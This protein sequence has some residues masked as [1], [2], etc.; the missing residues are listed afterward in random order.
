[1][2]LSSIKLFYMIE[3]SEHPFFT[4]N[5]LTNVSIH[6]YLHLPL[7]LHHIKT[8]T[9]GA[10]T[11]AIHDTTNSLQHRSINNTLIP[12]LPTTAHKVTYQQ[13][14]FLQCSEL[15]CLICI[16]NATMKTHFFTLKQLFLQSLFRHETAMIPAMKL[17]VF[18]NSYSL[19]PLNETNHTQNTLGARRKKA[20]IIFEPQNL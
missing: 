3:Y 10:N 1:M 12:L 5:G 19:A 17:C 11:T 15:A 7:D 16:Q 4:I 20:T 2:I 13:P 8:S 6:T 14:S 18:Q 9:L